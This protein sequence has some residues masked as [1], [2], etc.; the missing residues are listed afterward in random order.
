MKKRVSKNTVQ[1]K[2]ESKKTKKK[3]TVYIKIRR[4]IIG[5]NITRINGKG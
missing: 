5:V 1:H 2:I 4:Y 3:N